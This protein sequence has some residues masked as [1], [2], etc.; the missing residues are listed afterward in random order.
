[1]VGPTLP[2]PKVRGFFSF[3]LPAE[4]DLRVDPPAAVIAKPAPRNRRLTPPDPAPDR[5]RAT[6]PRPET[7][8]TRAQ[9]ARHA[10]T[11][12]LANAQIEIALHGRYRRAS[13]VN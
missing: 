8:F 6:V 7:P 13:D 12:Q 5:P 2:R 11:R 4:R 10:D 1:M 3:S 9:A